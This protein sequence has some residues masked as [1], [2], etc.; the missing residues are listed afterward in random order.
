MK[1]SHFEDLDYVV[2]RLLFSGGEGGQNHKRRCL[3]MSCPVQWFRDTRQT[4]VGSLH[5]AVIVFVI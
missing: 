2:K 5:F 4:A 3:N 1:H